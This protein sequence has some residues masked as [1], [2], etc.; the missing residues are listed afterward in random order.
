[1]ADALLLGMPTEAELSAQLAAT[2]YRRRGRG[3][4]LAFAI[5]GLGTLL[6]I[7]AVSYTVATG[8]GVWGNNI[9]VGWAFGIAPRPGDKALGKIAES[10]APWR[11]VAARLFWAYYRSHRGRDA[12]PIS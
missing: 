10:W 1:M 11:G 7:G 12:A 5:T 6:L 3:W 4:R 2:T 9:P 8:I